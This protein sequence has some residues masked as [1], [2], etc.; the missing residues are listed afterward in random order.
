MPGFHLKLL[1][2]LIFSIGL[3][4][5]TS[6]DDSTAT[7]PPVVNPPVVT[8]PVVTPPGT[9]TIDNGNIFTSGPVYLVSYNDENLTEAEFRQYDEYKKNSSAFE[10]INLT[11]AWMKGANGEGVNIG[12]A[13]D[14]VVNGHEFIGKNLTHID[15]VDFVVGNSNFHSEI[16]ASRLYTLDSHGSSV[17][18]IAAGNFDALRQ[19]SINVTDPDLLTGSG[20]VGVAYGANVI[21]LP[22]L[23]LGCVS[24]GCEVKEDFAGLVSPLQNADSSFVFS[25]NRDA[26]YEATV[27]ALLDQGAD[28]INMSF[29]FDTTLA[30]ITDAGIQTNASIAQSVARFTGAMNQSTTAEADQSVFVLA[31]G[32]YYNDWQDNDINYAD[33]PSFLAGLPIIVEDLQDVVIVA[34][35]LGTSLSRT[36]T[37]F[38]SNRCG[39]A[40]DFCVAAPGTVFTSLV[41]NAD[42]VYDDETNILDSLAASEITHSFANRLGTSFAAPV[43]TGSLAVIYDYF[44][45]TIS[46][47][48]TAQR[49][50]M[51]ADSSSCPTDICGRGIINVGAALDPIEGLSLQFSPNIQQVDSWGNALTNQIQPL[52]FAVESQYN[53]DGANPSTTQIANPLSMSI[54]QH[55]AWVVGEL[56]SNSIMYLDGLNSPFYEP[57]S[58]AI[59]IGESN[60]VES[61]CHNICTSNDIFSSDLQ[62]ADSIELSPDT[63]LHYSLSH[64]GEQIKFGRQVSAENNIQ[65]GYAHN[66]PLYLSD[67]S[68]ETSN[69]AYSRLFNSDVFAL[70]QSLDVANYMTVEFSDDKN[71]LK[72]ALC[73]ETSI[74]CSSLQYQFVDGFSNILNI[75]FMQK[76]NEFQNNVEGLGLELGGVL[77]Y[78]DKS[79]QLDALSLGYTWSLNRYVEVQHEFNQMSYQFDQQNESTSIFTGGEFAVAQYKTGLVWTSARQLLMLEVV[80]QSATSGGLNYNLPVLRTKQGQIMFDEFVIEFV[81]QVSRYLSLQ[82]QWSAD[83]FSSRKYNLMMQRQVTQSGNKNVFGLQIKQGF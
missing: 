35:A 61:N 45:G 57:F 41:N 3:F 12:I 46:P 81:P 58:E 38:Y 82:Y 30:A 25:A 70:T 9:V 37:A 71:H 44:N 83:L 54:S 10:L 74:Q 73:Y 53:F 42:P 66:R 64:E 65:F 6:S 69:L 63:T 13:D 18:A 75:G 47:R 32:N 2:I 60:N 68:F 29:G 50:L 5:C 26:F 39:E 48:E 22:I 19:S 76:S 1:F 4:A 11:A 21:N 8:P 62:Y 14:G 55:S 27:N 17:A 79:R 72:L 49:L 34:V 77:G 24:V 67:Q 80:D 23:T 78:N 40:S 15:T 36:T 20:M 31:A 43:I 16:N 7:D 51:S 56:S 59:E 52:A 28:F 33:N